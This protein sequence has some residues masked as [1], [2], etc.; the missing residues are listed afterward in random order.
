MV[1]IMLKQWKT[2]ITIAI[3]LTN[4][5]SS[6]GQ[7]L[8]GLPYNHAITNAISGGDKG[9]R[10]STIDTINVDTEFFDDFSTYHY[11][12]FP[13][14][15]HWVDR[16][17]YI[18]STYA[19]SMISLGV[20]TL[21]AFNENGYPYYS[22]HSSK[23]VPS[24]T[25]TSQPFKFLNTLKDTT[26]FSFFYQAGGKGDLPEGLINDIPGEEGKDSLLVDFFSVEENQWNKVFY[27]L[28]NTDT[29]LFKHVVLKVDSIYL[30]DGFKF[31]FRNYTSLPSN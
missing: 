31:R 3:I 26:Y 29:H 23:A 5:T 10:K 11:S 20:A 27:T 2:I 21:D 16:Y 8:S 4:I 28:D 12:V 30:E 9:Y 14:N 24:D 15:N 25:L 19:D 18:N 22:I 6:F 17:A 1:Q 7:K 13:R